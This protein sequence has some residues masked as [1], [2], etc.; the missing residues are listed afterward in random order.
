M[1]IGLSGSNIVNL[2]A[3]QLL[4]PL[5][6]SYLPNLEKNIWP[7]L[8]DPF[9]D[10]GSRYTVPYVVWS[11][12]IGWRNDKINEDIGAMDVPWDIFWHSQ[13][14][15]GQGRRSSTTS[16]TRSACRCSATRCTPASAPTSTPRTPASSRRPAATSSSSTD[17]CNI[18]V[19]ITDYQTLPE[20]KTW[21][22]HSWSG[23][24][25]GAAIY[26]MPKGVKPDVLSFWAPDTNGVVQN[27]FLCIGRHGE[28]P[29]AAHTPSST[30]CST[31]RT[32]TTTSSSTTATSRRRSTIDAELLIKQGLIPKS[33][34]DA[35]MRP[36][37]FAFNQELL[38]LSVDGRAALGRRLVEV[39]GR[40]GQMHSRWT[41][42]L[43]ALPG[44]A[45]LSDLLPRRLL[46]GRRGRVREPGHALGAGAV[47]EPARLE[48]RLRPRGAARTSGTAAS[49]SPS[50]SARS[51]SS[52][53]AMA[54]SLA[55]GYP[56]AYFAAR[57]TPAAGAGI[58]LLALVL[59]FWINYL[60][61]MLAWINLLSPERVGDEV[62][63]RGRASSGCSSGS[64]CSPSSGGWLDGQPS[65]VI[66][67][68]VYGYVPF[69]I[70]PLFALAR[71]H[72]PAPDRGGARPRREPV[73]GVRPRDAAAVGAGRSSP[74]RS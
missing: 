18:K 34:T 17:I 41:W 4:L 45:W 54:L 13:A 23:D 14:Y 49:T 16:A 48:R 70:L 31:R 68:L 52:A 29:G 38:Q 72:R 43:L 9:Y 22:H 33:L 56:V 50:S 20:A 30:S 61:R 51:P 36:D 46:R 53:I 32:P 15:R 28:E 35:V 12:G 3:Q 62:P 25:V 5:N 8:Q 47:L 26:Y 39:Q 21:L 2:I 67:A 60:M 69:L 11:D 37:Q 24:V 6:H 27:D 57:H 42:R 7:E 71:P 55:I 66:I 44:V 10:R 64:G 73:R 40:V 65:T 74:G 63:A 59:P 58:V 1:I 19:T